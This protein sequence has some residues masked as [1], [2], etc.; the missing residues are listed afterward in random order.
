MIKLVTMWIGYFFTCTR[1]KIPSATSARTDI[2]TEM[3]ASHMALNSTINAATIAIVPSVFV[4]IL[5]SDLFTFL[6]KCFLA[7]Y[8]QV[9]YYRVNDLGANQDGNG[10]QGLPVAGDQ[11]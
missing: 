4:F 3:R 7:A 9:M 2:A 10:N 11:R 6:L 8:Q 5:L 1:R